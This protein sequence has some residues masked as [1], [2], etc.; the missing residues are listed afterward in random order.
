M[1]PVGCKIALIRYA[2]DEPVESRVFLVTSVI[3]TGKDWR[4]SVWWGSGAGETDYSLASGRQKNRPTAPWRLSHDGA[5]A[6]LA[7]CCETLRVPRECSGALWW[8]NARHDSP[9]S[10]ALAGA[11]PET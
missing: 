1:T 4:V 8:A 6:I 2:G 5:K 10:Q 11:L 9:E 7:T 3:D